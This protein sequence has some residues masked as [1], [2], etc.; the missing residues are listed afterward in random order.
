MSPSGTPLLCVSLAH[1][2]NAAHIT[3]RPSSSTLRK[4]A[5]TSDHRAGSPAPTQ[6]ND[7]KPCDGAL[8]H[9]RN[10]SRRSHP[11]ERRPS[12]R[13]SRWSCPKTIVHGRRCGASGR[14][15]RRA[16]RPPRSNSPARRLAGPYYGGRR[17]R[18][19][20]TKA[21]PQWPDGSVTAKLGALPI[22]RTVR[23]K[24]PNLLGVAMSLHLFAFAWNVACPLLFTSRGAKRSKACHSDDEAK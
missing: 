17:A 2:L 11:S 3:P 6:A 7:R 14:Y 10:S 13:W 16:V 15:A 1:P 23:P 8:S 12:C 4:L 19:A 5:G 18:C 21:A 20:V 22:W 24:C 9:P